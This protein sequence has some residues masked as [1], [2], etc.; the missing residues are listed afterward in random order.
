M[1]NLKNN[2]WFLAVL[3]VCFGITSCGDVTELNV[4]PNSP[5]DVPASNLLTQAQYSMYN[6]LASRGLNAEWGMLMVQQ[7]SQNEYA[8][9]SRYLVDANSFDGTWSTVYASIINELSVAKAKI[10]ADENVPAGRKANQLA[11]IDIIMSDAYHLA[12]DSWGAIPYSEAIN[13]EFPNPSYDSQEAVYSGILSTMD[14]A[15]GSMDVNSG[16]FDSGDVIFGGNVASWKKLGASLLMRMAMRVSDVDAGMASTYVGKAAAYGLIES[17]MDNGMFVFDSDPSLSNPLWIDN[18]TNGRDDFAV[19]DVLVNTLEGMGDPRLTVFAAVNNDGEYRGMP[20]GLTDSE[21]T[22]L[23]SFTSR[24]AAGVRG[25]QAPHVIMDHAEVAFLY[26]EAIERGILTGSASD[27]YEAGITSSMEYWGFADASG[28]IDANGYGTG[29]WKEVIGLQKWIAF[30]MNGVQ[31]WA[32]WRRLDVPV[33][34]IPEAANNDVIP[35]RLPYPL[36]ETSNNSSFNYANPN[37]L[38]TKMWWDMN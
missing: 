21:A 25:A 29:T 34:A 5:T 33:L 24:P 1:K 16:S 28:Y 7:W 22:A 10:T 31:A 4:D 6:L 19:S 9:E 8:E 37:D 15:L 20:F 35:V 23:K 3:I 36:S 12:T 26:A 13:P 11:I 2:S 27:W 30:Y 14:A 17:N 38:S 32:E 18:V